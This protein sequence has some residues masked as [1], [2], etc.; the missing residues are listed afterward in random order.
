M[1]KTG[2]MAEGERRISVFHFLQ[3]GAGVHT[4]SLVRWVPETL[5]L[6]VKGPGCETNNL[7]PPCSQVEKM[8]KTHCQ[9]VDLYFM[10]LL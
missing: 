5:F 3:A 10:I 2:F 4:S 6:G 7:L 8:L 1:V 9:H